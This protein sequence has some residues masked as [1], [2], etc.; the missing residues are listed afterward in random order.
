VPLAGATLA[1]GLLGWAERLQTVHLFGEEMRGIYLFAVYLIQMVSLLVSNVLRAGAID[2]YENLGESPDLESASG[3]LR[4][5]TS[6][7]S[8]LM[9][10]VLSGLMLSSLYLVPAFLPAYLPVLDLL[11]WMVAAVFL[12]SFASFYVTSMNSA[13]FNLQFRLMMTTL[14]AVGLFVG[15]TWLGFSIGIGLVAA[16]MGKL[17]YSSTRV[18]VALISTGRPLSSIHSDFGRYHAGILLPAMGVLISSSFVFAGIR[19]DS[20]EYLIIFLPLALISLILGARVK[21]PEFNGANL[22]GFVAEMAPAVF[23][24]KSNHPKN[25]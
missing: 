15:V 6:L 4:Q 19:Q 21:R 2:I 16:G 17:A 8:L 7:I 1:F 18:V 12:E 23:S 14:V 24:W 20:T 11:P 13:H 3:M 9:P 25:R 10:A 5:L 22:F